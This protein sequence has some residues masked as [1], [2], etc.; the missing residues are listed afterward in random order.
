VSSRWRGTPAWGA[1]LAAAIAQAVAQTEAS[2]WW[3][4][5]F[6]SWLLLLA[7]RS[8]VSAV[9]LICQIAWDESTV[10]K[11]SAIKA[12]LVFSGMML[13]AMVGSYLSGRLVDGG[14]VASAV[15]WVLVIA[16]TFG[17]VL[18]AMVLL[19]R[20]GRPW[21]TVLPGALLFTFVIRAMLIATQIYFVDKLDRVDDLY[22]SLGIAIVTLLWLYLISWGWIAAAFI[23]A[24]FQGV[25]GA[26][27]APHGH[28]QAGPP[29]ER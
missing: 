27:A 23:N 21:P 15:T 29:L 7:A 1:A 19:P 16:T 25:I 17:A 5:L 24:G 9:R 6:G 2:A 4:L 8:A 12:P 13:V 18:G 22:G 14:V 11:V 10:P 28:P 20:A 26:T 3:L